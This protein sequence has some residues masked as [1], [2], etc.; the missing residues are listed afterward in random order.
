[1]F[2]RIV[3]NPAI[4]DG[5][6]CIKGTRI[7]VE[8]IRELMASGAPHPEIVRKSPQLTPEDVSQAVRYNGCDRCGAPA[9][10]H[11][12]EATFDTE[13]ATSDSSSCS[14]CKRCAKLGGEWPAWH[15]RV[16]GWLF[17]LA[18][19]PVAAHLRR[20]QSN[21]ESKHHP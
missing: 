1:M 13:S 15:V 17:W 7:S 3:S 14:L 8:F 2:D 4:L 20:K 11:L 19:A 16:F 5:K 18:I 6:P 10:L 21:H 9:V 12:C